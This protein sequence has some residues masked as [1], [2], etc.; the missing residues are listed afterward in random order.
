MVAMR[1][2]GICTSLRVKE[3]SLALQRI[4]V[5]ILLFGTRFCKLKLVLEQPVH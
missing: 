4:G 2:N 1:A 5:Q 3:G